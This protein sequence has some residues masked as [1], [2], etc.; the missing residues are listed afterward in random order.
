MRARQ[1]GECQ[2]SLPCA[3][4]HETRASETKKIGGAQPALGEGGLVD[5]IMVSVAW[6]IKPVP[7][8]IYPVRC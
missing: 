2:R 4:A 8:G 7:S 1:G 6:L 5:C 3:S